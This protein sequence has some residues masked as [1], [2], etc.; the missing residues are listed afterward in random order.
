MP[1]QEHFVANIC[2]PVW[3]SQG[4]VHRCSVTF[5]LKKVPRIAWVELWDG[6]CFLKMVPNIPFITKKF[7]KKRDF[8][9]YFLLNRIT[10]SFLVKKPFVTLLFYPLLFYDTQEQKFTMD[11]CSKLPVNA[12]AHKSLTSARFWR[13]I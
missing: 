5:S 6:I 9:A 13:R 3:Y 4:A 1:Q 11:L 12:T 7:M 10:T 2:L 8:V